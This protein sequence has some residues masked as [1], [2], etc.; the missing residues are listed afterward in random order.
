MVYKQPLRQSEG[1]VR[2]LVRLKGLDLPVPG[3]STLSRRC[4]GLSLPKL[5]RDQKDGGSGQKLVVDVVR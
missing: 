4:A 1:L 2:G 3:F 5:P